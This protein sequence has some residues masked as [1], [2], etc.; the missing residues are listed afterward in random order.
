MYS[1]VRSLAVGCVMRR[2]IRS[3]V[4]TR[5]WL[6]KT[7]F[8]VWPIAFAFDLPRLQSGLI[9][10]SQDDT[11]FMMI[12]PGLKLVVIWQESARGELRSRLHGYAVA[13]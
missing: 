8:V 1:S 10:P 13:Y 6:L 7:V 11:F 9:G 4:V 2:S 3:F 12:L 5:S